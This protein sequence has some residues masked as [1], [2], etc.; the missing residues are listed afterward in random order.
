MS[1]SRKLLRNFV[2]GSRQVIIRKDGD[3]GLPKSVWLAQLM[4]DPSFMSKADTIAK[5]HDIKGYSID[6]HRDESLIYNKYI[7]LLQQHAY[8]V[9]VKPARD[10]IPI[11]KTTQPTQSNVVTKPL[12]SVRVSGYR[13]PEQR[14]RDKLSFLE[15]VISYEVDRQ[16]GNH[17]MFNKPKPYNRWSDDPIKR[18]IQKEWVSEFTKNVNK[19]KYAQFA[20]VSYAGMG[21][22]KSAGEGGPE[23]EM[24]EILMNEVLSEAGVSQALGLQRVTQAGTVART[25]Q[26]EKA[27]RRSGMQGEI[28]DLTRSVMRSESVQNAIRQATPTQ[29]SMGGSDVQTQP[30]EP[31]EIKPSDIVREPDP[32]TH[33]QLIPDK[34]SKWEHPYDQIYPDVW[35]RDQDVRLG[36][37]TDIRTGVK[38][39]EESKTTK[40]HGGGR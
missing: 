34:S 40:P 21:G 39:R 14:E 37:Q 12:T 24:T 4:R 38:P 10:D 1:S 28:Q 19:G 15:D 26:E 13:T 8:G 30:V 36:G 3:N 2:N 22:G 18:A 25:E 6:N 31:R 20:N 11:I 33:D 16:L 27:D 29:P 35:R 23:I 17:D 5:E 9:T 32:Q 7:N